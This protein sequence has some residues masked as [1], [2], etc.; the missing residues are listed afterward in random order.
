MKKD[1]YEKTSFIRGSPS[2]TENQ[3]VVILPLHFFN[4]NPV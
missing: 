4:F 3:M 1:F 2:K